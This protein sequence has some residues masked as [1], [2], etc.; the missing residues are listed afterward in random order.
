MSWLSSQ[1]TLGTMWGP[2]TLPGPALEGSVQSQCKIWPLR[3]MQAAHWPQILPFLG[4]YVWFL[5]QIIF[6]STEMHFHSVCLFWRESCFLHKE[7]WKYCTKQANIL[8]TR[9]KASALP[10]DVCV[11]NLQSCLRKADVWFSLEFL[12]L[13]KILGY[14]SLFSLVQIP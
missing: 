10:S 6:R 14:Y 1:C 11:R 13:L 5:F 8:K 7:K 12:A 3:F 4:H 9:L 2:Q